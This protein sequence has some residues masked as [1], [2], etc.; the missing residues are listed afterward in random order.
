MQGNSTNVAQM[1]QRIEQCVIYAKSELVCLW[2]AM[3]ITRFS[4]AARLASTAVHYRH[5]ACADSA[6]GT[7]R[8]RAE[9]IESS[10]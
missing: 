1:H 7:T 5:G 4:V 8:A 3:T 6:G 2:K 9:R 10:V